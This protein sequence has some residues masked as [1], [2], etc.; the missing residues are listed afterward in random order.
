MYN[1]GVLVKDS[2]VKGSIINTGTVGQVGDRYTVS[3]QGGMAVGRIDR[4][5][6]LGWGAPPPSPPATPAAIP[7]P[8]PGSTALY[9]LCSK[10]S[11]RHESTAAFCSELG[12]PI[13]ADAKSLLYDADQWNREHINADGRTVVCEESTSGAGPHCRE[14]GGKLKP[15]SYSLKPG[16]IPITTSGSAAGAGAGASTTTAIRE[17]PTTEGKIKMKTIDTTS[18]S[19]T[20]G[21]KIYLNGD[22][23]EDKAALARL[24]MKVLQN[25]ETPLTEI[26]VQHGLTLSESKKGKYRGALKPD[27]EESGSITTT[28][29]AVT[30][31]G[32]RKALF[33]KSGPSDKETSRRGEIENHL[34]TI[35]KAL[36]DSGLKVVLFEANHGEK[37]QIAVVDTK[38]RHEISILL[39]TKGKEA[40]YES[41]AKLIRDFTQW[42]SDPT[43]TT[44]FAIELEYED[45]KHTTRIPKPKNLEDSASMERFIK[46]CA[47]LGI[48]IVKG[49]EHPFSSFQVGSYVPGFSIKKAR[50]V[51]VAKNKATNIKNAFEGR[52]SMNVVDALNAVN[53]TLEE[54]VPVWLQLRIRF[55]ELRDCLGDHGL[56]ATLTNPNNPSE[57]KITLS[58]GS[59]LTELERAR[60]EAKAESKMTFMERFLS[61]VTGEHSTTA[62]AAGAGSGAGEPTKPEDTADDPITLTKEQRENDAAAAASIES[63][64]GDQLRRLAGSGEG[65]GESKADRPPTETPAATLAEFA[66]AAVA[67]APPAS[68]ASSSVSTA[69]QTYGTYRVMDDD[70]DEI[71]GGPLNY[72]G[73]LSLIVNLRD[74]DASEYEFKIQISE[75]SLP[76]S[77]SFSSETLAIGN[78]LVAT[79]E[80]KSLLKALHGK[81]KVKMIDATCKEE[82]RAVFRL[83]KNL[84]TG[85]DPKAGATGGPKA[86]PVMHSAWR[87]H[88][89]PDALL[90]GTADSAPSA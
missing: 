65:E 47:T 28:S 8:Q 78:G 66:A 33:T 63:A 59:A 38:L 87:M 14:H 18:S 27:T 7:T 10:C 36:L 26:L 71:A 20:Y 41:D 15:I 85:V 16:A 31:E 70:G 52:G 76:K 61:F 5:D 22:A 4:V 86:P 84:A 34:G 80:A 54:G 55:D 74:E 57:T 58:K 42:L 89:V 69:E 51:A 75:P 83:I 30:D 88:G 44:P 2:T 60:I 81:F 25:P 68:L 37:P 9:I 13:T 64:R 77:A 45:E 40:V 53:F 67:S 6:R 24:V 46:Q 3:S 90:C 29:E 23:R 73:Y 32:T 50:M 56:S 21:Y 49:D 43:K 12:E 19:I 48:G 39:D 1:S 35:N 11:Q 82:E 17:T 72:D 62:S 79:P